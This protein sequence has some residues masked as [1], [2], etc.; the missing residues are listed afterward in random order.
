MKILVVEPFYT[1]SH[2]SWL[3]GFISN[4]SHE[5][6]KL[7]LDGYHW[8]WRMH[9]A[10]VTLANKYIAR[11]LQ[12]DL[13]LCSDMLDVNVFVGLLRQHIRNIPIGIYFH[14]NQISYPWSPE[15]KD[16]ELGR[17]RHYGFINYT[18]ALT[19]DFV[20][21]N[22]RYHQS[23]FLEGLHK[24][25][26]EFPDHQNLETIDIINDKSGVLPLGL[27]LKKFDPFIGKAI[28]PNE[29]PV[30]LWNHRWEYDKGPEL[31]FEVLFRLKEEGRKFKLMV[32]GKTYPRM[33]VIFDKAK[34]IL[35]DE[36]I[37][38]GYMENFEEY[39]R[40][41]SLADIL[42]VTSNQD[43]FGISVAEAIYC[44]CFP[45]LPSRLSYPEH[46]REDNCF[47]DNELE[48]YEK[49]TKLLDDHPRKPA[50]DL[51]IIEG[52]DWK[53]QILR[54]DETFSRLSAKFAFK[55]DT[56]E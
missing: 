1:E 16:T 36:I 27:D 13:I 39:A 38:W 43:F 4:S 32:L 26:S 51:T 25:L 8:K 11:R 41:L 18:S 15:D 34:Q 17:D 20:L 21:F 35:K 19:A 10:A 53:H 55:Y 47:Y 2:R 50:V 6:E 46:V 37:E 49:L 24:F 54:Y 44:R 14:E 29:V 31:F 30:I 45:L 5:V 7:T 3:D 40:C 9:G 33:P 12:P 52:Y 48:L 23:S 22:S 42:P 28:Q 56:S